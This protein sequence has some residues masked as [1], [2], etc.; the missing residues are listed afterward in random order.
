MKK[1][2]SSIAGLLLTASL[3]A[4]APQKMSYQAIIRDGSNV[5][6]TSTQVGIQISILQ[7]SGSGINNLSYRICNGS[8]ATR[9]IASRGCNDLLCF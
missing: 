6:V 4:Q 9:R 2:Y 8:S 1:I 3:W 5:L 7:G